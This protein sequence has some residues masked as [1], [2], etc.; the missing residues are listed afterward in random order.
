MLFPLLPLTNKLVI[1]I[2]NGFYS[3]TSFI[4]FKEYS[5]VVY[6][7]LTSVKNLLL[8]KNI[9]LNL[10]SCLEIPDVTRKE[11]CSKN[12]I[13]NDIPSP[14]IDKCCNHIYNNCYSCLKENKVPY[15]ALVNKL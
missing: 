11:R 12:Q 1:N 10:L 15:L 5:Y 6:S 2:I 4:N 8:L 13:I 7:T 3:K 9:D 14:V